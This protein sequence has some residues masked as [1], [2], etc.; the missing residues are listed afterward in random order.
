MHIMAGLLIVGFICNLL[1]RPVD[2]RNA[3]AEEPSSSAATA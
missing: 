1:V 2:A 3:V